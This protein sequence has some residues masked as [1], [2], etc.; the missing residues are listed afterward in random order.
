MDGHGSH[1]II[2][3][4]IVA[5][6]SAFAQLVVAECEVRLHALVDVG[7]D[8]LNARDKFKSSSNLVE[9]YNPSSID[10]CPTRWTIANSPCYGG[11]TA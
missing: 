10:Y 8:L 4:V 1:D 6:Q 2:A 7:K 5:L 11:V 9:N 3:L